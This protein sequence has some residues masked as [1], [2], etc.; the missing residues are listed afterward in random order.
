MEGKLLPNEQF[1]LA[2][3]KTELG[4]GKSVSI[5]Q[6]TRTI[7]HHGGRVI[8]NAILLMVVCTLVLLSGISV[9]GGTL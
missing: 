8:W 1:T 4:A 5:R 2:A 9:T 3:L 6:T 7:P